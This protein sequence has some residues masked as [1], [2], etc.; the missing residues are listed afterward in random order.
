MTKSGT[1]SASVLAVRRVVSVGGREAHW[2]GENGKFDEVKVNAAERDQ[3]E[4]HADICLF[5]ETGL[6]IPPP[7]SGVA[8]A[9]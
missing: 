7:F 1:G 8:D 6:I 2:N 4:T 9:S 5:A 3:S